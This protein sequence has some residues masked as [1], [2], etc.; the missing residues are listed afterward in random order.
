VLVLENMGSNYMALVVCKDLW[1][2]EDRQV[3]EVLVQ[4]RILVLVV[5]V[6]QRRRISHMLPRML[7]YQL[8]VVHLYSKADK[9]RAQVKAKDRVKVDRAALKAKAF[10]ATGLVTVLGDRVLEVD[11]KQAAI[12]S[13]ADLRVTLDIL[14]AEVNQT[15]MD[16][17]QA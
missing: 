17:S 13:K 3:L 8:V 12:I 7:A 2:L 11:L 1:V 4:R 5:L 10:T 14:R 6:R 9:D 16:T 15:S